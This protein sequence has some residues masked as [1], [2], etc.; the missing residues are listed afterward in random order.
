MYAFQKVQI[1]LLDES[2]CQLLI[3]DWVWW[4]DTEGKRHEG[5]LLWCP[6][7]MCVTVGRMEYWRLVESGYFQTKLKLLYRHNKPEVN[8]LTKD[9]NK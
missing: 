7:K 8:F 6:E 3:G 1:G 5:Q 4:E 9:I 2:G